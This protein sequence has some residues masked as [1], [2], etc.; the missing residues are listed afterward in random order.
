MSEVPAY[1]GDPAIAFGSR[2]VGVP[3]GYKRTD[4]GVI[5]NEWNVTTLGEIATIR[6]GTHQTPDYVSVGIPFYSVEHVTSRNF[7]N[8]KFISDEEHRFLTRTCRIEKGDILMTRIGSIGD[9]VLVDWDVDASFYVSLALLKIHGAFAPFIAAYSD[10]LAFKKE[11]DFH[12]LPSA[13]PRKINLGPI[14]DV[15]IPLPP[16]KSEQRAIAEALSDVDR[17]LKSLDAL[18][19]KKRAIKQATMQQLLTGKTRLPGFSGVWTKRTFGNHV[20]FL[21]HGTYSRQQLTKDDTV[22]YLHYGDI[23]KSSDSFLNPSA[24]DLPTLPSQF[25]NTLDL[26]EDG[27]L[28]LVDASEDVDGIG[29]SVE[30]TDLQN[31]QVVSGLHTIAARFDKSVLVDGFKAYLQ[32]CPPFRDHLRRLAAGT[33]VYATNRAH[34]ASTVMELPSPEEQ[35]AIAA[36]LSDMDSEITALEQRLDKTRAIK[37][38]MMQQLLTGRVRL[39]EPGRKLVHEQVAP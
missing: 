13:T 18:I 15:R 23:H 5:P 19:A 31:Q 14:S 27:D 12:S 35:R 4:I 24:S 29:K 36:M 1:I 6:D 16:K 11:V 20:K 9:C 21:R 2:Q 3:T 10:C 26:I 30:I 17:L 38:G 33:K 28:V 32:F 22:V 34:I 8:T 7:S 25:A 37:D 39:V